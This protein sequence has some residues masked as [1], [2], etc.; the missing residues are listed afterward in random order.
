MS[1]KLRNSHITIF[2]MLLGIFMVIY[3]LTCSTKCQGSFQYSLLS[4]YYYMKSHHISNFLSNQLKSWPYYQFYIYPIYLNFITIFSEITG[5]PPETFI[6]STTISALVPCLYFLLSKVLTKDNVISLLLAIY[7]FFL[8]F[9]SELPCSYTNG[10]T[11]PLFLI[12]VYLIIT[13]L[14]SGHS[15]KYYT[16][17]FLLWLSIWGTWHTMEQRLLL[18]SISLV[19]ICGILSIKKRIYK[20]YSIKIGILV[21]IMTILSLTIKWKLY[22]T[23][24]SLISANKIK[25]AYLYLFLNIKGT[26]NN[27]YLYIP[28]DTIYKELFYKGEL[29]IISIMGISFILELVKIYKTRILSKEVIYFVIPLS[30]TQVGFMVEYGL[31]GGA[32]PGLLFYMFPIASGVL[33]RDVSRSPNRMFKLVPYILIG[34]LVV[35]QIGMTTL[36]FNPQTF[37]PHPKSTYNDFDFGWYLS[38]VGEISPII[39]WRTAGFLILEASKQG[40]T[41][42]T[43]NPGY[44]TYS[45]IDHHTEKLDHILIINQIDINVPIITNMGWQKY[46]PFS[47]LLPKIFINPHENIIH[48]GAYLVASPTSCC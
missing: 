27:Q 21:T 5:I 35:T 40:Y 2:L 10:M 20:I 33:L 28:P 4:N 39:D 12:I 29:L 3:S 42:T 23:Q 34:I 7:I 22:A 32:G 15:S 25:E 38:N 9:T 41:L 18:F 47:E 8:S 44:K 43:I 46:K 1:L 6:K 31:I 37:G 48:S 30:I 45:K 11:F 17:V 14:L 13:R 16:I 24:L 19:G 26:G 36:Y